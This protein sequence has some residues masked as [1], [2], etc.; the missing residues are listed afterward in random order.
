VRATTPAI[1]AF[2]L[3]V[4]SDAQYSAQVYA[5]LSLV[6][7]GVILVTSFHGYDEYP[8]IQPP[9]TVFL[10]VLLGALLASLKPIATFHLQK[11]RKLKDIGNKL[12]PLEIISYISPLVIL[13]SLFYAWQAGEFLAV[14][15]FL[16]AA[17]NAPTY[18]PDAHPMAARFAIMLFLDC[19]AA[20]ALNIASLEANRRVGALGI[21]IAGSVK[22]IIIIVASVIAAGRPV[23]WL[24]LFGVAFTVV[25]SIWYAI[26]KNTGREKQVKIS[27]KNT[28]Y[29]KTDECTEKA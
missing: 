24:N 21:T 18:N 3:R 11:P 16:P 1:T 12:G 6:V 19:I 10:V 15:S 20:F 17:V 23:T 29:R 9:F 25:G 2:L 4:F 13:Q 26:E 14:Q 28:T 8:D 22:T 5:S 7:L 27:R